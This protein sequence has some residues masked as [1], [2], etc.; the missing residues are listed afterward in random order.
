MSNVLNV[1]IDGS[2]FA[3]D[4]DETIEFRFSKIKQKHVTKEGVIAFES[5]VMYKV[6]VFFD[7]S[8]DKEIT[9]YLKEKTGNYLIKVLGWFIKEDYSNYINSDACEEIINED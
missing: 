8:Q 7:G 1:T 2:K 5:G 9:S 4:E 6:E 3:C